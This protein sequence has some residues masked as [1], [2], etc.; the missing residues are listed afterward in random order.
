[1]NEK[2]IEKLEKLLIPVSAIIMSIIRAVMEIYGQDD[3]QKEDKEY[4]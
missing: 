2:L 4:D 3:E 1:M